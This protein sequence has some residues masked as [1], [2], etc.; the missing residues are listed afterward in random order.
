MKAF[1]SSIVI[2]ISIGLG[3]TNVKALKVIQHNTDWKVYRAGIEIPKSHFFR[4]VEDQENMALALEYEKQ[5]MT[6]KFK[7]SCFMCGNSSLGL[8][9]LVTD[10]QNMINVTLY[11]YIVTNILKRFIKEKSVDVSFEQ[12]ADLAKGYNDSLLGQA[13]IAI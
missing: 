13:K 12:A 6:R 3:Q 11:G 4:I 10:N 1:A 7:L 2:L 5:F 8:L 9:S